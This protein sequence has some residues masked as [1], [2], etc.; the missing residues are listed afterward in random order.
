MG[1]VVTLRALKTILEIA[2]SNAP[3]ASFFICNPDQKAGFTFG[4]APASSLMA[5]RS[6]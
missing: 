6:R 4:S 5:T 3:A 1:Y 2:F